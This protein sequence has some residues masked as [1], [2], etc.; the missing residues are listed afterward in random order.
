MPLSAWKAAWT[1]HSKHIESSLGTLTA[2][3]CTSPSKGLERKVVPREPSSLHLRAL[4]HA[5]PIA[6]D[7]C[8]VFHFSPVNCHIGVRSQISLPQLRSA[9]T[10][11]HCSLDRHSIYHYI[12]VG[13]HWMSLPPRGL[14]FNAVKVLCPPDVLPKHPALYISHFVCEIFVLHL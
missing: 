8:T 13:D 4:A 1:E 7:T 10:G 14:P 9:V 6:G 2:W 5:R 3:T 12:Y 11:F